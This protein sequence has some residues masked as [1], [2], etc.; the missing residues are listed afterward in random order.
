MGVKDIMKMCA[1]DKHEDCPY[2]SE[3]LQMCGLD[4]RSC[5]QLLMEDALD[6]IESLENKILAL[7]HKP[8]LCGECKH[9][10]EINGD[11]GLCD[12]FPA[13]IPVERIDGMPVV[14]RNEGM[15]EE[16]FCWEEKE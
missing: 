8:K 4:C 11:R 13:R 14:F 5:I 10:H 15:D 7:E 12:E 2:A 16:F 3:A 9:W 6:L 1:E